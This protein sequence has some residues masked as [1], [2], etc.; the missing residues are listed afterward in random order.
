MLEWARPALR[1]ADGC[2]S[3]QQCPAERHVDVHRHFSPKV[4]RRWRAVQASARKDLAS[5]RRLASRDARHRRRREGNSRMTE[6][7]EYR[8][9]PV[10]AQGNTGP[11]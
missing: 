3:R 1:D 2:G 4:A 7:R 9:V 10:T 11:V 5:D 8:I 6:V